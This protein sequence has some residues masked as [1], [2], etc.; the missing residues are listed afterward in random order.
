MRYVNIPM[1][2]RAA[3]RLVGWHTDEGGWIDNVPGE[4]HYQ[5][6]DITRDNLGPL[7]DDW[8]TAQT[9][10]ARALLKIDLNDNW[11][12]TPGLM[13]QEANVKG[14]WYDNE[15]YTGEEFE[16]SSFFPAYQDEDWYQASL[17]LEGQIGDLNL[18]YA[19]AYLDRDVESQYDYSGYAEYLDYAYA[20]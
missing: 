11:S 13:Y 4:I 15:L 14:T 1:G 16:I 19:G 10:G 6:G 20:S 5:I 8:N 9:S 3:V 7:E 18:I 17:T 2:D 12:V